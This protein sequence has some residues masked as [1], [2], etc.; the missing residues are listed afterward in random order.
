M[1]LRLLLDGVRMNCGGHMGTEPPLEPA[2]KTPFGLVYATAG[3]YYRDKVEL[4][5]TPTI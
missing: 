3:L 1:L 5:L 4:A 2:I